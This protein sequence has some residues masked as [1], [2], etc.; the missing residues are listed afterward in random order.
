[1]SSSPAQPSAQ[2]LPHLLGLVAGPLLAGLMFVFLPD[3]LSD[4]ARTFGG[5]F[6]VGCGDVDYRTHPFACHSLIRLWFVC[7]G[8]LGHDEIGLCGLFLIP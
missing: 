6:N 7:V 5:N 3:S 4:S 2:H 8:W 1:M